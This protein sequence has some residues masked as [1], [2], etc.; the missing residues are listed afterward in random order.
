MYIMNHSLR[1]VRKPGPF[2][3]QKV[4][5]CKHLFV[6]GLNKRSGADNKGRMTQGVISLRKHLQCVGFSAI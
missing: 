6:S 3:V 5:S 1:C 2:R 4:K